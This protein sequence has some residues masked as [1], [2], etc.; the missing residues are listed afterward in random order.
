[1]LSAAI[2]V[3]SWTFIHGNDELESKSKFINVKMWEKLVGIIGFSQKNQFD[4][5]S[6]L[7]WKLNI[8]VIKDHEYDKM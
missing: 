3:T 6:A 7:W 5:D 8:D 1:M 4:K 2:L